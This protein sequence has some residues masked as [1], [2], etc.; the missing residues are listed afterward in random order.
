M[1]FKHNINNPSLPR[2]DELRRA[3]LQTI[4]K[5]EGTTVA[6]GPSLGR[7]ASNVSSE[8][9]SPSPEVEPVSSDP[10]LNDEIAR[11][12][13]KLQQKDEFIEELK[14]SHERAYVS[15]KATMLQDLTALRDKH[16]EELKLLADDYTNALTEK[17]QMVGFS[18]N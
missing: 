6:K 10:N 17:E 9:S 18:L 14:D 7:K 1:S 5:K 3:K 13:I 12:K 2:L 15:A 8:D 4:V 16:V 11:L